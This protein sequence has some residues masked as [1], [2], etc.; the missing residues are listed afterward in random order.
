MIESLG[1][2]IFLLKQTIETSFQEMASC[3]AFFIP[4]TNQLST[5]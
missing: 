3:I 2:G 4:T 1:I 5:Q